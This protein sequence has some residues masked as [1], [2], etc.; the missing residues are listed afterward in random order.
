MPCHDTGRYDFPWSNQTL[1]DEN[2]ELMQLLCEAC[3][4]LAESKLLKPRTDLHRW[5]KKHII[6]DK[7][8]V[9]R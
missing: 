4:L 5:Y 6:R 7:K 8:K 2:G 9:K 1:V 3:K